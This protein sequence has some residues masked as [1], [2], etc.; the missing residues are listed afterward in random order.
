ML[1]TY[2]PDS[3]KIFCRILITPIILEIMKITLKHLC[4]AILLSTAIQTTQ[5]IAQDLPQKPDSI[6]KLN[7][8]FS[9]VE[10]QPEFPGGKEEMTKYIQKNLKYPT[11]ARENGI[12]G[13]V[14]VSFTVERDGSITDIEV[15]RSPAEKLS[16]EAIR[17][18]KNMPKWKPGL[19]KGNPVRVKL[20][21]PITFKLPKNTLHR[22]NTCF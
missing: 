20:M 19:L 22:N 2:F 3:S 14:I 9:V 12:Q 15:L 11:F 4:L 5:G 8:I 18:V 16:Q 10:K 17:I 1:G 21:L 6:K 13:R 7:T